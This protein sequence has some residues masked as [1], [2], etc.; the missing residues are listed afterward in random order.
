MHVMRERQDSST[1]VY[2]LKA[3]VLLF[4]G[5][6]LTAMDGINTKQRNLLQPVVYAGY[7]FNRWKE[8]RIDK[9]NT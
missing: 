2:W 6:I 7:G 1:S 3:W 5:L 9:F 8:E 4:D